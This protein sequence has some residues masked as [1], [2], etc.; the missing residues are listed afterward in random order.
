MGW[1]L[2]QFRPILNGSSG[3]EPE[4]TL[5]HLLRLTYP[6][7]GESSPHAE[8]LFLLREESKLASCGFP[9]V[10]VFLTPES[11]HCAESRWP[12]RLCFTYPGIG[13]SSPRAESS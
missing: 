6:G 12:S 2:S 11:S 5:P 1:S 3:G 13:E 9:S 7:I 10:F 4:S 8:S